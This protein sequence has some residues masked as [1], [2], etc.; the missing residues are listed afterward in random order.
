[1]HNELSQFFKYSKVSPFDKNLSLTDLNTNQFDTVS[2]FGKGTQSSSTTTV[3]TLATID[4][5]TNNS[6]ST[7]LPPTSPSVFFFIDS[8]AE[9]NNSKKS[10]VS[11]ESESVSNKDI[12]MHSFIPPLNCPPTPPPLQNFLF[13][14]SLNLG[15]NRDDYSA[16]SLVKLSDSTQK[17]TKNDEDKSDSIIKPNFNQINDLCKIDLS[18]RFST[19]ITARPFQ[20][21][22]KGKILPN[23]TL[24][25]NENFSSNQT[26][27]CTKYFL[28]D[29]LKSKTTPKQLISSLFL[30]DDQLLN[31]SFIKSGINTLKHSTS[32]NYKHENSIKGRNIKVY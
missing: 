14:S 21:I 7:R 23:N 31:P 15:S 12:Q 9:F 10:T 1:M 24:M 29:H 20:P 16:S 11:F 2:T 18:N 22:Q 4:H 3:T 27:K 13:G 26:L 6:C 5:K 25:I 32:I 19:M 30:N 28:N 17:S 8:K